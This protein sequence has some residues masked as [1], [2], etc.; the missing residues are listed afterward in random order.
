MQMLT[1][2]VSMNAWS[3]SYAFLAQQELIKYG[4]ETAIAYFYHEKDLNQA[5]LSGE[6]QL[7]STPL[8]QLPTSLPQGITIAALNDRCS[9]AHNLVI[10][11]KAIEEAETLFLRKNA[12]VCVSLAIEKAQLAAIRPDLVIERKDQT[13]ID[14]LTDLNA[15]L[16]D[17]CLIPASTNRVFDYDETEFKIISLSPKE[18]VPIVGR[19][20]VA[21]LTAE[22][23]L[24][25]RR[26]LKTLHH[27]SVS[28]VTNIERQVKWLFN[29]ENIAAYCQQ[30]GSRNYHL[31]AA[32]L[33]DGNLKKTR[34]SQ[35]THLGLAERC[36]EILMQ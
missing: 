10:H 29:D 14:M 4:A 36:K 31:W 9:A 19:G 13:P 6:I 3:K 8:S 26:F 33:V 15:N 2:G 28:A 16:Y 17:A 18:F 20:V 23:D 1:I 25:T 30:D 5:L 35:S 27:P 7:I 24:A 34:L 32:A 11:F 21:F 12:H 22:D